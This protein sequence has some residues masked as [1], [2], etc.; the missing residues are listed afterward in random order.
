MPVSYKFPQKIKEVEIN[1]NINWNRKH[2]QALVTNYSK[3]SFFKEY[4]DLFEKAFSRD[5]IFL[6]DL[7][8][9]LIRKLCKIL[10]LGDKQTVIA[11]DLNPTD[12][13]TERLIDICKS[14][15]ADTY[16][17]GKDG[18]KYMDLNR[19]KQEGINVI[20]QDFIHPVYPQLYDKFQSNA[21]VIDLL[22]NCG[23][24]SLK[25]IADYN[26]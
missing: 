4:I 23:P 25:K 19:F 1:N 7:N 22:F 24:E 12:E 5:W 20:F 6:S 14:L 2:L 8:I 3:S 16:L 17:S 21:S 11:S 10:G 18:G 26:P 13:P 15:G 9:F